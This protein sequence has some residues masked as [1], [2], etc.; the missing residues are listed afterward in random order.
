M[1][2]SSRGWNK[3]FSDCKQSGKRDADI[4]VNEEKT[5]KNSTIFTHSEQG[6]TKPETIENLG[7]QSSKLKASGEFLFN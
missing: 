6:A 4:C 3:G 7:Q 1:V 5:E 2:S